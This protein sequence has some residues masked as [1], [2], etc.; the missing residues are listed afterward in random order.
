MSET[1][2]RTR[3][4]RRGTSIIEV[5]VAMIV[6]SISVLGMA[7]GSVVATR[8][9]VIAEVKTE[10]TTVRQ[11]TLERLRALPFDSVADGIMDAHDP[12]PRSLRAIYVTPKDEK[13]SLGIPLDDTKADVLSPFGW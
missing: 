9:H 1:L 2:E 4:D 11:N 12:F 10:R 7:G 13:L 8:Q 6:L 5:V 3:S